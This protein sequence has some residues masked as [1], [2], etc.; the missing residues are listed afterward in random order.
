MT[1]SKPGKY[2]TLYRFRIHYRPDGPGAPT[3]TWGT[4]AY[5]TEGAELNFY[6]GPDADGWSIVRIERVQA[7]HV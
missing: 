2:G 6:N 1:V 7:S 4:W 5:D 3:F